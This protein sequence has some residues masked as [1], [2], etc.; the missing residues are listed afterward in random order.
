VNYEEFRREQRVAESV[1]EQPMAKLIVDIAKSIRRS[2]Q[3]G[4][5]RNILLNASAVISHALN[6]I[7][8][9]AEKATILFNEGACY[10]QQDHIRFTHLGVENVSELQQHCLLRGLGGFSI[11]REVTPND[12]LAMLNAWR[13]VV[14]EGSIKLRYRLSLGKLSAERNR[15][16]LQGSSPFSYI[17]H[18][19]VHGLLAAYSLVLPPSSQKATLLFARLLARVRGSLLE[20]S[21]G[22]L[23][24]SCASSVLRVINEIID[25]I[26]NDVFRSRLLAWTTLRSVERRIVHHNASTAIFAIASGRELGLDRSRV[27]AMAMAGALHDTMIDAED[28]QGHRLWAETCHCALREPKFSRSTLFRM[29]LP[30][31]QLLLHLLDLQKLNGKEPLFESHLLAMSCAFDRD[32]RDSY[33]PAYQALRAVLSDKSFHRAATTA[34][35]AALGVH[36]RGTLLR[37]TDGHLAVVLDNGRHRLHRPLVRLLQ[38][39]DGVKLHEKAFVDLL[40]PNA[41]RIEGAVDER[42]LNID[43]MQ[44]VVE[45]ISREFDDFS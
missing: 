36:P 8:S 21:T 25:E 11:D 22:A 28:P 44:A 42:L 40:D 6:A 34:L 45:G 20:M 15:L 12:A 1:R 39:S 43:V 5:E 23:S 26:D 29:I 10:V 2:R 24:N 4:S 35:V 7:N 18:G 41:P 3:A 14:P 32:T 19:E 17:P 30:Y 9:L 31:E 16:E 37:L 13:A 27:A 38:R 33:A